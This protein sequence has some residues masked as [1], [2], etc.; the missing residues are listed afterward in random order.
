MANFEHPLKGGSLKSIKL[1]SSEAIHDERGLSIDLQLITF[2]VLILHG[3]Y[4][5][6]LFLFN[7]KEWTLL[8]FF[9]L[10]LT[11]SVTIVVSDDDLLLKWLSINFTW[12]LKISILSY[13]WLSFFILKMTRSFT[14]KTRSRWFIGYGISL[15]LY[16]GFIAIAPASLVFWTVEYKVFSIYYILPVVI[17]IYMFGR[18]VAASRD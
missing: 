4:S 6:I 2:V 5:C 17:S 18:M 15:L 14:I 1:G 12:D 11:A 10:L 7:P 13:S 9:L 3:L 8:D 16:S